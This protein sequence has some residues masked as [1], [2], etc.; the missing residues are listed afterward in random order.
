MPL[1]RGRAGA[2]GG[3]AGLDSAGRLV[4]ESAR[5]DDP[6]STLFPDEFLVRTLSGLAV[7]RRGGWAELFLERTETLRGEWDGRTGLRILSGAREGFALR[8]VGSARQDH[9]A[10]E[11][12]HPG[13]I[14]EACRDF[15]LPPGGGSLPEKK[16]A[17]GGEPQEERHIAGLLESMVGKL[18]QLPAPGP[19]ISIS[20]ETRKRFVAVVA[21]GQRPKRDTVTR[22]ILSCR[23]ATTAG[24]LSLGNGAADLDCLLE[25]H[26]PDAMLHEILMRRHEE[27]EA[28]EAPEGESAVVLAP[29]TGG[30]FFHEAC[31]HAL[32]GDLVLR[33]ASVFRDLLGRKIAPEFVGAMDDSTQPGLEGSYVWDDEGTAGR[34]TVLI[35]RGTLKSFLADRVAGGR[36]GC[37]TTG[38]G[39]RE[40]FRDIPMSRMSNT[41]LMAGEEDPEEIL[42]ATPR[43]VFVRRLE[44]GRVDTGTGEFLFRAASGSL[45]EDGR[46]T[47]PLRPFSIA[48][49]GLEAL[50]EIDRVG[51]D[52]SFGTG[53]GSCGKEGQKVP[54][55]V[56][57][58]TLRIRRL[59][60]RPG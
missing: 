49:N 14:Q 56:G 5:M 43:G 30:V 34:G 60:L 1:A 52:L 4:P 31:G 47:A 11:G 29:G 37:G 18:A 15:R 13:S 23:L 33:E 28:R 51:R 8:R 54:V 50:R 59:G 22:A 27:G 35:A 24:A 57:Q 38:N 32:E 9:L 2:G 17:P 39:R 16:S 58:P 55:A 36:L 48:G 42:R 41:F 40:S 53:A 44:G 7:E 20:L 26:P 45:I 25:R 6:L 10:V 21:S 46:L 19:E 3:R 12:L